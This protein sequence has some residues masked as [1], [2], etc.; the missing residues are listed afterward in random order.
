MASSVTVAALELIAA[1]GSNIVGCLLL[2]ENDTQD[3]AQKDYNK[4]SHPTNDG[5]N[6]D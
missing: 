3:D 4:T 2:K 5:K 1:D 6:E